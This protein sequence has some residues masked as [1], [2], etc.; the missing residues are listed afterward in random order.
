MISA[1]AATYAHLNICSQSG[2]TGPLHRD[3]EGTN[4]RQKVPFSTM[5]SRVDWC[6]WRLLSHCPGALNKQ[7]PDCLRIVVEGE[8][9]G[10]G[11]GAERP[12]PSGEER[13]SSGC[14]EE[15]LQ[16]RS[17]DQGCWGRYEHGWPRAPCVLECNSFQKIVMLWLCT[18][19]ACSLI[20]ENNNNHTA[21]LI[22][23]RM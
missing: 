1:P 21:D 10:A 22:F 5:V 20:I 8:E 6:K 7:A 9:R 23:L 2:A 17:Q 19:L 12:S 18:K 16:W 4:R 13:F 14:H 3:C 15:A 11:P